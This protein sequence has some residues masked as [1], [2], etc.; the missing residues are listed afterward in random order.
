V[1]SRRRATRAAASAA[2]LRRAGGTAAAERRRSPAAR[3]FAPAAPRRRWRA[4][5]HLVCSC[6]PAP[7]NADA[8]PAYRAPSPVRAGSRRCAAAASSL[9]ASSFL[10]ASQGALLRRRGARNSAAGGAGHAA[11]ARSRRAARTRA[12]IADPVDAAGAAAGEADALSLYVQKHG[13]KRL[14]RKVRQAARRCSAAATRPYRLAK[15]SNA[16]AE[17]TRAQLLS[18][19]PHRVWQTRLARARAAPP[20]A[21]SHAAAPPRLNALRL[22]RS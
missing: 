10:P 9:R 22:P 19:G 11:S 14:I 16:A 2:Q 3:P 7:A 13:G 15:T 8:A 5:I 6:E 20:R 4:F 21:A 1:L 18:L 12:A 17:E